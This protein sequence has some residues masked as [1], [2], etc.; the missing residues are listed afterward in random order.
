VCTKIKYA[1]KG[2]RFQDVG[3]HQKEFDDTENYSTIGVPKMF[4]TVAALFN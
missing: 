3:I 4:P 1:L 2:Q